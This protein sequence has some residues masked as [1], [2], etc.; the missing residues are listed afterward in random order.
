MGTAHIPFTIGEADFTIEV[1][2]RITNRGFSGSYDEPP[3]PPEWEHDPP[4]LYRDWRVD[5]LTEAANR[6]NT[7]LEIP[8]W[9]FD[10][11]NEGDW[12]E[13]QIAGFVMEDEPDEPE[14]ERED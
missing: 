11:I 1:E 2:Y 3:E 13:E 10:L 8:Q 4:K 9:L 14:Y 7:P 6:R 5:D 12:L